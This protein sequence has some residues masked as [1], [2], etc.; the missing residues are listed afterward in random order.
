MS[1]FI[2][3]VFVGFVILNF[4]RHSDREF[5]R[6]NCPYDRN[7]RNC[8]WQALHMRPQTHPVPHTQAQLAVY[9]V[10]DSARFEM[11]IGLFIVLNVVAMCFQHYG[12]SQE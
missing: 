6:R 12:Q 2:I 10:V 3:Q 7:L 4:Q 11:V 9:R 8:I 5:V 1:F